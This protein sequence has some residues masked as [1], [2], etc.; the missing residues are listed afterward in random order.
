MTFE[1]LTKSSFKL[2][3]M[4]F[5]LFKESMLVSNERVPRNDLG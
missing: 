4:N 1:R 3:V 2:S 5:S